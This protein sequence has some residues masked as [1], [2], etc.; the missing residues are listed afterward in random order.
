MIAGG[1]SDSYNVGNRQLGFKAE[2]DL[3]TSGTMACT[4]R[5]RSSEL[6][7]CM[8]LLLVLGDAGALR[9]KVN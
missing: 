5:A 1:R 4:P 8:R 2:V 9:L 7:R 6:G 3:K